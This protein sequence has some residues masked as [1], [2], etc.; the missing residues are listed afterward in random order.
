[1]KWL[2]RN[3]KPKD[4]TVKKCIPL[5]LGTSVLLLGGCCTTPRAIRWEYKVAAGPNLFAGGPGG[6]SS[7]KAL[8]ARQAFLN[9]L[10][11]DG[12]VLVSETDR[13]TFYFIRQA[14]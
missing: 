4:K 9:E 7:D 13:R 2:G 1:M 8:E 10:G 11:K 3:R 6:G 5:L 12:W 14:R